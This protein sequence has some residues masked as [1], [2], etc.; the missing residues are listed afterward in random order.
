MDI[1]NHAQSIRVLCQVIL[2]L[3]VL[4]IGPHLSKVSN[5]QY[6]FIRADNDMKLFRLC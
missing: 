4:D 6:L 2:L 1:S 3:P 5:L